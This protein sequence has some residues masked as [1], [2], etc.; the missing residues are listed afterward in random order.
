MVWSNPDTKKATAWYLCIGPTSQLLYQG[1]EIKPVERKPEE[2]LCTESKK[3]SAGLQVRSPWTT[4]FFGHSLLQNLAIMLKFG[5]SYAYSVLAE[6]E[7]QSFS[8]LLSFVM[9]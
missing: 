7:W 6:A 5:V 1:A 8:D 3:W 4:K 2:L 9:W